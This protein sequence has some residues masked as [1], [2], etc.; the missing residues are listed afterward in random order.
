[1]P[2]KVAGVGSTTSKK[3]TFPLDSKKGNNSYLKTT[4]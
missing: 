2:S 4:I 3:Q 1:M